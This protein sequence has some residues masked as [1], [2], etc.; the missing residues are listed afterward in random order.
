MRST[1]LAVAVATMI[2]LAF[3]ACA[4][5]AGPAGPQGE[6]GEQGPAGP[7]GPQGEPGPAGTPG[8]GTPGRPGANGTNGTNGTSGGLGASAPTTFAASTSTS[9]FLNPLNV[10]SGRWLVVAS[11]TVEYT[12]AAN[13]NVDCSADYV[14]GGGSIQFV[15]VVQKQLSGLGFIESHTASLIITVPSGQTASIGAECASGGSNAA[16]RL[17]TLAVTEVP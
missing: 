12:G 10:D 9:A 11:V 14:I 2:V 5:P 1:P 16:T 6:P 17:I 7:A 13:F 3:T 4:G 8:V 15:P